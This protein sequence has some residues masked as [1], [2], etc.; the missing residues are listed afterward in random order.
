LNR[1]LRPW[2]MFL[3]RSP[4]AFSAEMACTNREY[5]RQSLIRIELTVSHRLL[6]TIRQGDYY[7]LTHDFDSCSSFRSPSCANKMTDDA[8]QTWA[9]WK[10]SIMHMRIAP[11][12]LK[13]AFARRRRYVCPFI[14]V[15]C[16]NEQEL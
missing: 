4:R 15:G 5:K 14:L 7:I 13:K 12:G 9:H 6:N 1:S 11:S 3:I 10:W 16:V 2:L 8:L